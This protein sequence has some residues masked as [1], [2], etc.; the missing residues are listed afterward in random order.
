M[1]QREIYFL[2]AKPAGRQTGRKAAKGNRNY[3]FAPWRLCA[4]N[5][6]FKKSAAAD[7]L[8][9]FTLI[10]KEKLRRSI[11]WKDLIKTLARQS[12]KR[13]VHRLVGSLDP[14][15]HPLGA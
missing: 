8:L 7:D 4:L 5:F 14:D 9:F 1:P 13:Y 3:S 10:L 12:G 11:G 6:F 15:S 2:R